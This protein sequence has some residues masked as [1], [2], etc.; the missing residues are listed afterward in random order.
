[1]HG[2]FVGRNSEI[3]GLT[4]A[5]QARTSGLLTV[6]G[7]GGVGKSRLLREWLQRQHGLSAYVCDLVDCRTD[8]DVCAVVAEA[9]GAALPSSP[10]PRGVAHVLSTSLGRRCAGALVVLDNVEAVAPAVA[11]LLRL[12]FR[13]AAATMFVVTSRVRLGL[14][15][16]HTMIIEPLSVTAAR[17]PSAAELLLQDRLA[18]AGIHVSDTQRAFVQTI[19]H[20][21][22]GVPLA[23]ELVAPR[24]RML[25]LAE[26]S[27]RL[28]PLGADEAGGLD[29]A[30]SRVVEA[31]FALLSEAEQHGLLVCS[32]FR[33]G[34]TLPAAEA[35]LGAAGLDVVQALVDAS[36]LRVQLHDDAPARF[37]FF[38]A[39]RGFASAKLAETPTEQQRM[40]RLHARYFAARPW[41]GASRAQASCSDVSAEEIRALGWE[42][43]NM[44]AAV[45]RLLAERALDAS[46]T[47]LALSL[48]VALEPLRLLRGNAST[49]LG[50]LRSALASARPAT[51][52]PALLLAATL[53]A[54]RVAFEL[55][56]E[57]QAHAQF[58]AALEL[59]LQCADRVAEGHARCGLARALAQEGRWRDALAELDEAKLCALRVHDDGLLHLTMALASFLGSELSD[60]E[61]QLV[62]LARAAA[63][64][65]R[66]GDVRASVLWTIQLGRAYVDFDR[67]DRAQVALNTG[68]DGARAI[69]DHRNEGLALFG[70]GGLLLSEEEMQGARAHYTQAVTVF[71]E[72][73]RVRDQG[74][75]LG[76]LGV[77]C[78]L[79]AQIDDADLAYAQSR[80]AL[81]AAGDTPNELLFGLFAA[82]LSAERGAIT[83]A[84][85]AF[86]V[87]G[88]QVQDCVGSGMRPAALRSLRVVLRVAQAQA[89]YARGDTVTFEAHMAEAESDLAASRERP[90]SVHSTRPSY[91]WRDVSLDVRLA[92]RL[93]ARALGAVVRPDQCLVVAPGEARFRDLSSG[94]WVSLGRRAV[95]QRLL[96]KLV[97]ERLAHPGHVLDAST[98]IAAAWPGE[99]M[100]PK[101]AK[102]RLHV[103]LGTLRK[104]GLAPV[105]E[106]DGAGWRLNPSVPLL[107]K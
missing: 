65:D 41:R 50:W 54:A 24:A 56:D 82:A 31:S 26:V 16:E 48:L 93:A 12:W 85:T 91:D 95:L 43:D 70:L 38:R 96:R 107:R 25:S 20:S 46:G 17:G 61:E 22:E 40:A 89:A 79:L 9:I 30:M 87:L 62:P 75:A 76:Y 58:K 88:R 37:E 47:E 32:V 23:I 44:V 52:A 84:Q 13:T 15:E 103:A 74:Y 2:T 63:Y 77:A 45:E 57:A 94:A 86:E 8:D 78:H 51:P 35:L 73:G 81:R 36:L 90:P 66:C 27:A 18:A 97:K 72:L 5:L 14:P 28:S 10:S 3:A 4:A 11:R 39:V 98:L 102:N 83:Q 29:S 59:S 21:L 33:G 80:T 67:L 68:L 7:F 71:G 69:G 42:H 100:T 55:G 92:A 6:L 19:V 60:S 1:L 99:R 104:L 64:F 105:I 101:A 34:F 49:Y 53:S 106:H